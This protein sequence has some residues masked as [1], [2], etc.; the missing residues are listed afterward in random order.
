[1]FVGAGVAVA[2]GAAAVVDV[3]EDEVTGAEVVE[4]EDKPVVG[5]VEGREPGEVQIYP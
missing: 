2:I 1:M 4:E 5:V 3:G